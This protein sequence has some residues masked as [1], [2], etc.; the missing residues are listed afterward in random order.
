MMKPVL[1]K[2]MRHLLGVLFAIIAI[3]TIGTLGFHLLGGPQYSWLDCF[4]MTFITISTIGY[5]EAVDVT[6][7]E[8]G[9]LFTIFIGMSGI[10]VMGYALTA[11]T[12][13]I[14]EGQF[15][16]VRWRNKMEKKI[17]QLQGHY[18][19]CGMGLVGSNV[20]HGL[21]LSGHDFVVVEVEN[22]HL[23][24]Y[25]EEHPAALYVNGDATDDDVLLAAGIKY[26]RGVFAVAHEDNQN[27]VICL[28]AKQLNPNVRVIAR[29]HQIK[30]FAKLRSAGAD[31][32]VSPDYSG[33]RR[34]LSAMVRPHAAGFIDDV[35]EGEGD[36]SMEE[37]FVP[38]DLHGQP[39]SVLYKSNRDTVI[40]ALKR[41]DG[42]I[43]N[44]APEHLLEK[45][46]VLIAMV[47]VRGHS[48]L[49]G[50]VTK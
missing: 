46:D 40:V 12:A 31:E 23:K 29:C 48:R 41:P 42:M 28:T 1:S 27:L 39:L 20:V 10:G 36:L 6:H 24:S 38:E 19:V 9:R 22:Q 25:A 49:A 32:I 13:F 33:G 14:L 16:Q 50:L 37:F 26:A 30:N 47:T 18:I 3:L 4:Y 44:P 15:N 34:L 45:D 17:A 2:P 8:Y 5:T 43:F 21:A 11:A 7:Y 35:M